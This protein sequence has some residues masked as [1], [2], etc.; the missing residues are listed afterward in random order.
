M[1]TS[2]GGIMTDTSDAEAVEVQHAVDEVLPFGRMFIYGLQHVLS[3][4]AGVVAV[5]L[6]R[7]QYLPVDAA[8]PLRAADVRDRRDHL[9]V[10]C[11][12][13]DHD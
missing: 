13:G 10:H 7:C 2:E 12:A 1:K 8:V 6:R 3:M 5:P 4:Y 9:D 11:D